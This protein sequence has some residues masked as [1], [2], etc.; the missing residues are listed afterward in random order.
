MFQ[1]LIQDEKDKAKYSFLKVKKEDTKIEYEEVEDTSTGE[2]KKVEKVVGLGTYSS[3]I[4]EETDP[5]AFEKKC[6]EL[7]QTYSRSQLKFADIKEYAVDF[8]WDLDEKE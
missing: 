4:Y 7:L 5:V 6:T 2:I 8:I 3:V 1:I